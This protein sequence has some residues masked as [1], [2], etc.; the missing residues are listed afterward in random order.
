MEMENQ[1]NMLFL[2]GVGI[3]RA[4]SSMQKK[5]VST[6]TVTLEHSLWHAAGNSQVTQINDFYNTVQRS[7][8]ETIFRTQNYE[9]ALRGAHFNFAHSNRRDNYKWVLGM[10]QIKFAEKHM[11]LHTLFHTFS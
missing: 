11:N 8:A 1:S 10:S 2:Q 6:H 7:R 3:L 5:H 9:S 4:P